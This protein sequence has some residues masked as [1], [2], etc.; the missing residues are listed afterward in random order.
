MKTYMVLT[1]WFNMD[2]RLGQLALELSSERQE[3][4]ILDLYSGRLVSE[5]KLCNPRIQTKGIGFE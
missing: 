4:Q 1:I 5:A 3:V 2:R